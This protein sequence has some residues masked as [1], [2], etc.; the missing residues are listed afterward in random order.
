[1]VVHLS[2]SQPSAAA[3]PLVAAEP[4]AAQFAAEQ[5]VASLLVVKRAHPV[6]VADVAAAAELAAAPVVSPDDQF[7]QFARPSSPDHDWQ[8]VAVAAEQEPAVLQD[9]QLARPASSPD[10]GLRAQ[11][12]Q[13]PEPVEQVFPRI[14][15]IRSSAPHCH[16]HVRPAP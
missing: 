2:V 6:V 3:E 14:A 16:C 8:A 11:F 15:L 1:M 10:R 7:A 12:G 13:E 9:D 5:L 4:S